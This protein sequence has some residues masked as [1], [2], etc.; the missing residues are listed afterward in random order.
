ML[1]W[2]FAASG[3]NKVR[4]VSPEGSSTVAIERREDIWRGTDFMDLAEFVRET[5]EEGY[6]ARVVLQSTCGCRSS[7]F[8]LA[9][10]PT[11]GCA[12]RT[13]TSCGEAAFL[14][15]SDE[16]WAEAE[17]EV[18]LCDCGSQEHEVAGGFSLRDGEE[19]RWITIGRR[20][21]SCG[22]MDVPVDWEIDYSPTEHLFERT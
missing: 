5:T 6:S 13:C 15:D 20:C 8:R 7:V 2:S 12:Q 3:V 21:A 4:K 18:V 17:P 22:S 9:A 16:Y 11:E 14:G 19:V 1:R 10:D